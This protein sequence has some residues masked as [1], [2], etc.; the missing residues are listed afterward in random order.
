MRRIIF[1]LRPFNS[2]SAQHPAQMQRVHCGDAGAL[3][4]FIACRNAGRLRD[5]RQQERHV[6]VRARRADGEVRLRPAALLEVL[7]AGG[8]VLRL[9]VLGG[10]PKRQDLVPA[11][12]GTVA[13]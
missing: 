3:C 12:V 10:L 6:G 9:C 2:A 13:P 8:E 4:R 1:Y 5:A 11:T 7:D